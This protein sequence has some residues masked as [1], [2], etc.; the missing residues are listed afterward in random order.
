MF[1]IS[2][3]FWLFIILLA[4]WNLF[5]IIEKRQALKDR[6][7]DYSNKESSESDAEPE[8]IA[9]IYC[10]TCATFAAVEGCDRTDCGIVD[11]S[12]G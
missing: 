7:D 5:R 12:N 9:A 2:K 11:Q 8:A 4:V 6:N 10:S 3:L 1:T